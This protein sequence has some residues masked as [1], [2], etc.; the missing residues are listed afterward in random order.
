MIKP[1]DFFNVLKEEGVDFFTGVPDSLLKEFLACIADNTCPEKNIITAN[2]GG[3]V[4][5]ATGY[6]LA[7]RRLALVYMQNSGL[8]N[9][10]NPLLSLADPHVY[11]IPM[12]LLVGWRGEPGVKDEPQHIKQGQ[13]MLGMLEVMEIPYAIID[14]R[15]SDGKQVV[16]NA[17][18]IAT[19]KNA[20]YA[21]VVRKGAFEKYENKHDTKAREQLSQMER[22]N[23]I[24]YI[25]SALGERDILVSSTGM[26]SREVFELRE[27]ARQ[28]HNRDFLTVGSMGHASQIALGISLSNPQRAV[29]CLDGDGAAIMHLGSMA[30]IGYVGPANFRHVV[31]N[32]GAHDSVGGQPTAG[33]KMNFSAIALACGYKSVES[34]STIPDLKLAMEQMRNHAGPSFLEVKVKIGARST[35]G[36]PTT[37]PAQN[38]KQFMEF[39]EE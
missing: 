37:T 17:V 13:T 38:K 35:L 22:E 19:E 11:G 28:G 20:P 12:L 7:T 18:E 2:E 33:T 6:Y 29:Y 25:L 14:G 9:A 26:I 24:K 31:L 36:R 10:V 39:I 32:N 23:A 21:I 27:S 34:V 1:E 8:G 5:L 3:A 4:A 30:I 15:S 16:R